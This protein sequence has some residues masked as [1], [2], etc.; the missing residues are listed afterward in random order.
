[1]KMWQ[2]L[3]DNNVVIMR[4][5]YFNS[6]PIENFFDQV[7]AYNYRNNDPSCH[8]FMCTLQVII[9]DKGDKIS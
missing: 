4:P 7:R 3:N 9:G 8:S 6:D 2:F 5:R 1:M